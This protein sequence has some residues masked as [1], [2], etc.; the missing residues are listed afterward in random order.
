MD[1]K[2]IL[3]LQTIFGRTPIG[4]FIGQSLIP[5]I[6]NS[7]NNPELQDEEIIC[8]SNCGFVLEGNYFY[9]GCKNCGSKD[10]DFWVKK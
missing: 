1:I 7:I 2:T 5:M 9:N 6:E 3:R 4:R 8:C 10:F